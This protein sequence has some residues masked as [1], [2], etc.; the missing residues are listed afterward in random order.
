V[1]DGA[2]VLTGAAASSVCAS[3]VKDVSAAQE[4]TGGSQT[5]DGV[6]SRPTAPPLTRCWLTIA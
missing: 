2:V 5:Q 1:R 4:R 6:V 3:V